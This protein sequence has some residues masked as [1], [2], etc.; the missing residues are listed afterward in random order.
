[1]QDTEEGFWGKMAP[2]SPGTADTIDGGDGDHHPLPGTGYD[3]RP[4]AQWERGK[5][6]EMRPWI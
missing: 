1:M 6:P 5:Q 4:P 3:T 2:E